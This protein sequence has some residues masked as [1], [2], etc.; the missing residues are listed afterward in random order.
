MDVSLYDYLID[1]WTSELSPLFC[2]LDTTRLVNRTAFSIAEEIASDAVGALQIPALTPPYPQERQVA[3]L[4]SKVGTFYWFAAANTDFPTTPPS[5]LV[6][7]P[8]SR[9]CTMLQEWVGAMYAPTLAFVFVAR[10]ITRPEPGAWPTH[11]S[12]LWSANPEIVADA[13]HYLHTIA[14]ATQESPI[15]PLRLPAFTP[16]VR[17]MERFYQRFSTSI[18][19][20]GERQPYAFFEHA[21]FCYTLTVDQEGTPHLATIT[22]DIESFLG[23]SASELEAMDW[24]SLNVENSTNE[25]RIWE[26]AI[27]TATPNQRETQWRTRDGQ[28]RWTTEYLLP[29]WNIREQRVVKLHGA[30]RDI[31]SAKAAAQY[32]NSSE[33]NYHHLFENAPVMLVLT[34]SQ[35]DIPYLLNCNELFC[36][37]LGYER[38]ELIGRPVTDIYSPQSRLALARD[39]LYQQ[40]LH[41]ATVDVERELLAKD[42][43]LIPTQ[44]KSVPRRNNNGDV[45]GTQSAFVDLRER[46]RIEEVL[47]QAN[48]ELEHRIAERTAS[49]EIANR[50]LNVKLDEI[51]HAQAEIRVSQQRL[52]DFFESTTDLIMI[53]DEA[54]HFLYTNPAWRETFGYSWDDLQTLISDDIFHPDDMAKVLQQF[55]DAYRQNLTSFRVECRFVTRTGEILICEGN[56]TYRFDENHKAEAQMIFRDITAQK[57][58]EARRRQEDERYRFVVDSLRHTVLAVFDR[59]LRYTLAAGTSLEFIGLSPAD[60]EDKPIYEVLSA[61]EIELLEPYYKKAL[62]GESTTITINF[63]DRTFEVHIQPYWEA[64]EITGGI[65]SAFDFTETITLIQERREQEQRYR[66][67]VQNIPNTAVLLLDPNFNI[68]LADGPALASFGVAGPDLETHNFVTLSTP[69][70]QEFLVPALHSALQGN[71]E[72]VEFGFRDQVFDT[73]VLPV[74]MDNAVLGC[75]LIAQDVTAQRREERLQREQE[76]R[77]RLVVRRIPNT[78]ILMFDRNM[79]FT[80]SEGPVLADGLLRAELAEGKRMQDILP[81]RFRVSAEEM[82]QK[83]LQ[84]TSSHLEYAFEDQIFDIQMLPIE[85]SGTISGGMLV[86]QDITLRKEAEKRLQESEARYRLVAENMP[87][88]AVFLFDTDMRFSLAAGSALLRSTYSSES[89][90]GRLLSDT[91]PP[92]SFDKLAPIYQAALR[93]ER[94]SIDIPAQERVHNVRAMPV[95]IDGKVVGGLILS[96]DVTERKMAEEAL[97][98]AKDAAEMATRAKSTFLANMSHEIRTPLNAMV[99]ALSLLQASELTASQ[100]EYSDIVR[101]STDS[102]LALISD[103]LDFSRIEADKLTLEAKP[104]ALRTCIEESLDLIYPQAA[105][106]HLEMTYRMDTNVPETVIG[107]KHRIRQILVN[108]LSNAVKFTLHG[109]VQLTINAQPIDATHSTVL[110]TV[111]DTGIGLGPEQHELIFDAFTQGDTTSTRRFG[112]SGLGLAI[113][114][115][116]TLLMEG[117]ISV[118]STPGLGSAFHVSLPLPVAKAQATAFP[119]QEVPI[120]AGKRILV[121]IPHAGLRQIVSEQVRLWG[122]RPLVA[123]LEQT[124]LAFV[125]QTSIGFDAIIWDDTRP[126]RDEGLFHKTLHTRVDQ[127]RLPLILLTASHLADSQTRTPN[128]RIITKPFKPGRLYEALIDTVRAREIVPQKSIAPHLFDNTLA[129]R[130]PLRILLV[131][132]NLV[133]QR[134][135]LAILEQLGYMADCVSDG[136]QAVTMLDYQVYDVILMDIQMPLMGGVEATQHIRAKSET[137]HQ[138]YIIALTANAMHGDREMYLAAGMNAYLSKPLDITD[139]QSAL[140]QAAK[141]KPSTR[142]QATLSPVPVLD[143]AKLTTHYMALG[144]E[145]RQHLIT[146][147]DSFVNETPGRVQEIQYAMAIPRLDKVQNTIRTLRALSISFS[148]PALVERCNT[149]DEHIRVGRITEASVLISRLSDDAHILIAALLAWRRDILNSRN[150][151]NR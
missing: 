74:E 95:E 86:L 31:T 107:D 41:G 48:I 11:F 4:V 36:T 122:M 55:E 129:R 75:L 104:F 99:G 38:H 119:Q 82:F 12:L 120:L 44:L 127:H 91:V 5:N 27:Q 147:L 43:T 9:D 16:D 61:A 106:K 15:A 141:A 59:S 19:G 70:M 124:A 151:P 39:G 137:L 89:L 100:R 1:R 66:L 73:Q 14:A 115:R 133:N 54:H 20:T 78:G 139:L 47:K 3:T 52:E 114:K 112:G 126:I 45:I 21:D 81:P 13:L 42:G 109:E 118:E 136:Q 123:A 63:R 105:A 40:V 134:V 6:I 102:L 92:D 93:G 35:E 26:A 128:Q 88:S 135:T 2:T 103:I 18:A 113:C 87:D 84:G 144:A 145:Q 57:A 49:L 101:M 111:H 22:Q 25:N 71:P 143:R 96:Q 83:T 76:E 7:S 67:V 132:D 79:V 131:E 110:F 17:Q 150:T 60:M 98:E 65:L 50:V 10:G 140:Q 32:A 33:S 146:Q 53:T 142:S 24:G 77:Y 90:E 23:Y 64:D 108:L 30:L 68:T 121:I 8:L 117:T 56:A 34:E 138:P 51:E 72:R 58:E 69:E 28:I 116:L 149:I 125:R 85:V 130:Y 46:H 29:E 94:L 37:T 62:E 148:G 80:L 97:R